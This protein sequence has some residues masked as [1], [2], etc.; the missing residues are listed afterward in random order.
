MKKVSGEKG[1][2]LIELLIVIAVLGVLAAVVLVAINPLEQLARGRDAGRKSTLGQLS[3]SM[4]A[5]FA[6]RGGIYPAGANTWL[7]ALSVAGELKTPPGDITYGG[8]VVPCSVAS[9][10]NNGYCY[11]TDSG[12]SMAVIYTRLES[13]SDN[14][15]CPGASPAGYTLAYFVWSSQDSRAGIV[16]RASGAASEPASP[17]GGYTY[18]Q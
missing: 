10:R 12:N 18:L 2:T 4:Q 14:S 3:N 9:N 13:V 17:V 1:F 6:A 15:K 8:G 5:Y 16:C 7:T 11:M